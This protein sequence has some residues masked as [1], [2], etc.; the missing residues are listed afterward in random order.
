MRD[1]SIEADA[2]LLLRD[3]NPALFDKPQ[4]LDVED[5]AENYLGLRLHYDNLSNDGSIWG[6]MVF[7]DTQVP[8]YVPEQKRADFSPVEGGTVLIDNS[9]LEAERYREFN[10]TMM[11]ECGHKIYHTQYYRKEDP[12]SISLLTAARKQIP[13]TACRDVDVQGTRIGG[14][15]LLVSDQDWLEHHAKFFSSSALMPA[16]MVKRVYEESEVEKNMGYYEGKGIEIEFVLEL[17]HIFRVSGQSANIRIRQ[18]GLDF[19][20]FKGR[21]PELFEPKPKILDCYIPDPS[22]YAYDF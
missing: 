12:P 8:I 19:A 22:D 15:R 21:H 16:S 4:A 5:F 2:E 9:L 7:Y 3:Y 6:R 14:Q 10:S 17:M 1:V 13:A 18:L 20:T 11:H